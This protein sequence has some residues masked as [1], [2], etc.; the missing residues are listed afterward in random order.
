MKV[1][2]KWQPALLTT[3]CKFNRYCTWLAE[4]HKP[5]WGIPLPETLLTMLNE[6]RGNGST[7]LMEDMWI[8]RTPGALP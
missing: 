6:L 2:K 1:I 5:E 7:I 4:L 3:I 8:T